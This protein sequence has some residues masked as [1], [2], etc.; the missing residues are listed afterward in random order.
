MDD[1]GRGCGRVT[2]EEVRGSGRPWECPGRRVA[3]DRPAADRPDPMQPEA[4]QP[5]PIQPDPSRPDPSRRDLDTPGSS[6]PGPLDQPAGDQLP[7]DRA[8]GAVADRTGDADPDH[9]RP[10]GA[11]PRVSVRDAVH[12][13]DAVGV[14]DSLAVARLLDALVRARP[15]SIGTNSLTTFDAL[16]ARPGPKLRLFGGRVVA[17]RSATAAVKGMGGVTA[18]RLDVAFVSGRLVDGEIRVPAAVH[19]PRSAMLLSARRTYLV[20][21]DTPETGADE[22]VLAPLADVD[23]LVVVEPPPGAAARVPCPAGPRPTED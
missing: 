17:G 5:D 21:D 19:A 4:I 12:A 1:A 20:L 6:W 18:S 8:T 3:A 11:M 15:A 9:G 7:G 22:R 2:G 16:R 13:G 23:G 14:D 10:A